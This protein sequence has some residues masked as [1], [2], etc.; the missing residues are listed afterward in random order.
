MDLTFAVSFLLVFFKPREI[1]VLP[2]SKHL[3]AIV[4]SFT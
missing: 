2:V 1:I 4:V 3:N